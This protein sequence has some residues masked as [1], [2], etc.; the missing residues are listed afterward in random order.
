M[1]KDIVSKLI[2][3][4]DAH[5]QLGQLYGLMALSIFQLGLKNLNEINT[6]QTDCIQILKETIS[7]QRNFIR[8]L[9]QQS[10]GTISESLNLDIILSKSRKILRNNSKLN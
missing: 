8:N 7:K 5:N 6:E 4:Q 3:M 1:E 2:D 10:G 9:G